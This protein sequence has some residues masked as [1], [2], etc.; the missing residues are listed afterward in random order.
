M[1]SPKL[2]LGILALPFIYIIIDVC[3]SAYD[4]FFS[5]C[6]FNQW[7]SVCIFA[8]WVLWVFL[9]FKKKRKKKKTTLTLFFSFFFFLF[10][11]FSLFASVF[12]QDCVPWFQQLKTNTVMAGAS[13]SSLLTSVRFVH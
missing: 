13:F 7:R 12:V 11:I 8:I 3:L 10:P 5:L 2:V 9:Y 6:F 1:G 4:L